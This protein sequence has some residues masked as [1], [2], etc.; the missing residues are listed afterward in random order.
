MISKELFIGMALK[1]I[2]EHFSRWMLDIHGNNYD[3]GQTWKSST[4]NKNSFVPIKIFHDSSSLTLLTT[5]IILDD[6]TKEWGFIK[7]DFS[8]T[9]SRK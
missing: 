6:N 4:I 8:K 1:N 7:I 2:Q 9:L 3:L 5:I